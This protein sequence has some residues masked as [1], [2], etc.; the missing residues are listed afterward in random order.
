MNSLLEAVL[1]RVNILDVVSQYV[2]L[3]RAGKDYLGLCPFHK[4]K[5]PSFTVSV[6]KQIYYCFGCHEG[7]NAVH[8]LAK[9]DHVNFSEALESLANQLGIKI[10]NRPAGKRMP[11]LEA[12]LKLADYYHANL[13]K[14]GAA[15]AYLEKRGITSATMEEF[16]LGYS[17]RARYTQEFS[18]MIGVPFDLLFSIG[19]FKMRG[20]DIYD[21]FRGRIVIPILD[22]NSKVIGFG[23]RALEKEALPKYLNSPESAVFTKRSVLYGLDKARKEIAEKD[24]AIV[25]EG[26]FD[27]IALHQVGVRNAVATLGTS[28]TEEQ[29]SRLRNY[30]ENITLMLDGDEAGMKSTLRLIGLLGEMGIN[31][32]MVVLPPQHDPDSFVREKGLSG[33]QELME[34]RKA[35]LDYSFDFHMKRCGLSTLEGKRAFIKTILPQL[36]GMK[37]G[38]VKRLYVQRLAQLTGVEEYCF[39][40]SIHEKRIEGA[41][42]GE[43]QNATVERKIIGICLNR[44]SLMQLLKGK[45][46][47]RYIADGESQQV[48][49]RMIEQYEQQGCLEVRRFVAMLEGDELKNSVLSSALEVADYDAEEMEKVILDY[50]QHIER[51][52]LKEEAREITE[53]LA[54]AEQKGDQEALAQLLELKRQVVQGMR[55]KS[56]KGGQHVR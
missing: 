14:S 49:D 42:R 55:S 46:V 12:L 28:V 23:G 6:E 44:P 7:G 51:K 35:I 48:L 8:F 56:A 31:G 10:T 29:I 25:V 1:E 24:E 53:R 54:E 21:I 17:E 2:K 16:R 9:Y 39:W 34:S 13:R 38:I 15:R 47:K 18:K 52:R 37:D 40:D 22:I 20:S 32:R 4:E 26:Y 30:T 50:C 27:L 33:F 45:G 5:T 43:R 36:E 41:D 19:L 11:I 3:R